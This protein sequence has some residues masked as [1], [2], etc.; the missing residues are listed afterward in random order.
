M[1]DHT[2][3]SFKGPS[4]ALVKEKLEPADDVTMKTKCVYLAWKLYNRN[5]EI[6]I[7][8]KGIGTKEKLVG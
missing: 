6:S 4:R 8:Y 5:K 2:C 3:R 7:I 1:V